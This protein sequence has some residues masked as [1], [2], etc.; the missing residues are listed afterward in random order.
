MRYV[1]IVIAIILAMILFMTGCATT[2]E[3]ESYYEPVHVYR[4]KT[5][6]RIP[7]KQ[8]IV[9]YHHTTHTKSYYKSYYPKRSRVIKK[10][11]HKHFVKGRSGFFVHSH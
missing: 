6:K 5:V 7:V 2:V 3:Y 11:R 1:L 4:V 9:T 10:R 8:R